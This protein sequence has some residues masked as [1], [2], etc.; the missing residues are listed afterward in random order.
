MS[1][2]TQR[3]LAAIIS[4]DIVGYS[5]LMGMDEAGTLAALRQLRSEL[6]GPAV[7]E[8]RGIIVKN[9]GDGWLVTFDNAADAVTC[10]IKLQEMLSDHEVLKL[11]IG[12]HVGDITHADADI[13]GD[14]V[15]IAARLQEIADPGTII[16]SDVARRSIDG[17]LAADFYD[18]G[19]KALK[20]IA[21]PLTVYGWNMT[22]MSKSQLTLNLP[23][24]PSIAVLPFDNM[25]GDPE[26][27]YFADGMTEDII[28]SLS[29]NR[30]FFVVARNSTFTFK[31][32]AVEIAEVAAK[33]GVRYVLEG[34][35]R[36]SGNR[37]RIT[38][39]LVDAGTTHHVWADRYDRELKD[40]FELQDEMTQTIVAALEPEVAVAE[41]ERAIRKAPENLDAWQMFQRGMWHHY[42]FNRQDNIEAGR[43]FRAAIDADPAFAQAHAALAHTGYWD[44]LYGFVDD[45]DATLAQAEASARQALVFDEREPFAHFALGRV[46]TLSAQYD[47]ALKQLRRSIDLNPNFAHAH[48]GLALVHI[49]MGQVDEGIQHADVALRL[50]PADPSRWTFLFGRSL[51]LLVQGHFEEAVHWAGEASTQADAGF[52]TYCVVAAA[53]VG[54]GDQEEAE[55]QLASALRIKPDLN[56]DFVGSKLQFATPAHKEILIGG[57]R[58]AGLPE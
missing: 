42:R 43:L 20:N 22:R 12:L 17:K 41:R 4:A 58:T 44:V 1:K 39:Q 2:G 38:A 54:L 7:S 11:R 32:A 18:L 55:S 3:K 27:E 52:W 26:Q 8:H 19:Q 51:G 40:I 30:S 9:M 21:G 35:I 5:H 23:D 10:A 15:N 37:I 25:S 53:R 56:L 50:S 14:G 34:S 24:K 45:A 6:L 36:K 48:F 49:L 47:T 29:K 31:G 16:I 57:L 13:Y 33:L 28:T 46:L